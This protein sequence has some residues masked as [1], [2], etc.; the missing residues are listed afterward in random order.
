MTGALSQVLKLR[1]VEFIWI[2]NNSINPTQ[3]NK[4][5]IGFIAQ[6]VMEIVPELAYQMPDGYYGV[7]YGNTVALLTE[8]LQQQNKLIEEYDSELQVV[9]QRAKEK[10]L[11]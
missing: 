8:A 2:E 1:G 7:K 11:I 9:E 5:D 10:G 6:E 3:W 4:K